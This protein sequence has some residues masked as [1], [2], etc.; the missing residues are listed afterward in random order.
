MH[1]FGAR[2]GQLIRIKRGMESLTQAGLASLA[3][4]DSTKASRISD[5]ERGKIA[6]PHQSTID[7]L[8]VA[9]QLS[10]TDVLAC[11][12]TQQNELPRNL[13]ENLVLRFG[14]KN[15]DAPTPD[16]EAFL[17]LKA[18][19]YNELK[20]ELHK[21]TQLLPSAEE[22]LASVGQNLNDGKLERANLLL[23]AVEKQIL[24]RESA[25][26][27]NI[28]YHFNY[29]KGQCAAL[30]GEYA[31]CGENLIKA[32][33]YLDETSPL[34]GHYFREN[35]A[36]DLFNEYARYGGEGV[37]ASAALTEADAE[38][39]HKR[40][41]FQPWAVSQSNLAGYFLEAADGVDGADKRAL[42]ERVVQI[43]KDVIEAS[44]AVNETFSWA[45]HQSGLGSAYVLLAEVSEGDTRTEYLNH[46]EKHL[47]LGLKF[48]SKSECPRQWAATKGAL[49]SLSAERAQS[50]IGIEEKDLYET[51]ISLWREAQ[52]AYEDQ[53]LPG[54][55]AAF[56]NNIG[57]ALVLLSKCQGVDDPIETVEQAI[58]EHEFAIEACYEDGNPLM[59]ATSIGCLGVAHLTMADIDPVNKSE[60]L[61]LALLN[62]EN[63]LKAYDNFPSPKARLQVVKIMDQIQNAK[64]QED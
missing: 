37:L 9:L 38:F 48:Q 47:N 39:F 32:S 34:A 45:L 35:T 64:Q 55:H 7:A 23:R 11:R 26:D 4:G 15:P 54:Y 61:E 40:G 1:S 5:L 49:A 12:E 62:L 13:L 2:F 30:R 63:A 53:W 3:F 41:E 14:S 43:H 33:K 22:L 57:R 29:M 20:G 52:S 50:A 60:R 16:L 58:E 8:T 46:S 19:E 27:A 36:K 17:K 28:L 21:L 24:S 18:R 6:N 10:S 44:A 42:L 51:A 25:V 59:W 31:E 56:H